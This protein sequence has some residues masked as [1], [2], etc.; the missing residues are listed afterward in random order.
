MA[1]YNSSQLAQLAANSSDLLRPAEY[2]GRVRV[3]SFDYTVPAGGVATGKSVALCNIPAGATILGGIFAHEDVGNKITF[4]DATSA[5]KF[6]GEISMASASTSSVEFANTIA[7]NAGL[8]ITSASVL[9]AY[10]VG[11]W[12]QAKVFRGAILYCVD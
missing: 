6:S 10:S 12:T 3:A 1:D 5:D 7:K 9:T 11:A 2:N 4:G 8:R